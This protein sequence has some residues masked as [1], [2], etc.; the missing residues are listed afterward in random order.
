MRKGILPGIVLVLALSA[1]YL[2]SSN[3][4]GLNRVAMDLGFSEREE[5][6]ETTA[7]L[8]YGKILDR[9]LGTLLVGG[10]AWGAG[11][12]LARRKAA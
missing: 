1:S 6:S 12:W 11:R 5:T 2:A 9:V 10:L 4:D 7:M 8:N 3:P